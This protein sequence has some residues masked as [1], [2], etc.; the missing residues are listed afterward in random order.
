MIIDKNFTQSENKGKTLSL[1]RDVFIDNQ[2]TDDI[3]MHFKN[4]TNILKEC[5][6]EIGELDQRNPK[7]KK[8]CNILRGL[9]CEFKEECMR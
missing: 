8:M 5:V 9:E 4:R 7:D 2:K 6:K 1:M 3:L